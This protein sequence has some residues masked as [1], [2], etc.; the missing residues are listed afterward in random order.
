MGSPQRQASPKT[1]RV[2][3]HRNRSLSPAERSQRGTSG[4]EGDDIDGERLTV[5]VDQT[6]DGRLGFSVRGGA[7][8]G[9]H[10]FISKVEPHSA[11]AQAGLCVGDK[12]LEVNG[13]SLENISMSSAVK[14]LTGHRR[15]RLVLQRVG[16]VPGV[17]Y[18]NEKTTWVD[19]IHRRMVVD[20][21]GAALSDSRSDAALCRTV[22]LQTSLSQPFLGLNIRGGTEYGLGIYVSKLDPGGLA[23]Q[24]GIKMG[25]QILS[26]NG[27][28]FEDVTHSRAVEVLK[29]RSHV[30]LIIKEAGRYPAY[31]EM[32]AE[33]TWMDKR[34]SKMYHSSSQGSDSHSSASSMSSGTPLSSVAGLSQATLPLCLPFGSQMV[35][36][37]SFSEDQFSSDHADDAFHTEQMETSLRRGPTELLQ[38]SAIR[39]AG[40]EDRKG[41]EENKEGRKTSLLMA[42]SRPSPPIRRTQSHM[43]VSEDEQR[44]Q[45][46]KQRESRENGQSPPQ[47]SRTL[48]GLRW[49]R[50]SSKSPSRSEPGHGTKNDGLSDLDMLTQVEEMAAKLLEEE[51]AAVVMEICRRYTEKQMDY[52]LDLYTYRVSYTYTREQELKTLVLPLLAILDRPEKLLLLRE[53]RMLVVKDDLQ[54]FNG[55]VAPLE[56]EAYDILKR[57]SRRSSPLRSPQAGHA[58]KRH[59]ITP[60][61]DQQGGFEL[62][63]AEDV[64][65]RNRLLEELKRIQVTQQQGEMSEASRAF[66]PLLDIP[67][68]SYSH[69]DSPKP[70]ETSLVFPNWLLT[71]NTSPAPDIGLVNSSEDQSHLENSRSKRWRLPFRNGHAETKANRQDNE[72]QDVFFTV[73]DTPHPRR[74]LLSQVFGPLKRSQSSTVPSA[75]SSGQK[76]K[77]KRGLARSGSEGSHHDD[78]IDQ[79]YELKTVSISKTKQSLGISISGGVESRVQPMVR[80]EKIFPGGAAS[81]N[82]ILKVGSGGCYRVSV[83]MG[84]PWR[85]C[86]WVGGLSSREVSNGVMLDCHGVAQNGSGSS[87]VTSPA[88][89]LVETPNESVCGGTVVST[90]MDGLVVTRQTSRRP[91]VAPPPP[92]PHHLQELCEDVQAA[93]DGLSQDSIRNLYSSIPRRL[94]CWAGFE[95]VSVD[96]VSLQGITHEDAVEIIRQA[97]SNKHVDPMELVVKVPKHSLLG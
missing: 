57:R 30:T 73:V 31:Q 77:S 88:L 80:I 14:V 28:S 94:A 72:E 43:T 97:F 48:F 59:L 84:G 51:D 52:S 76:Q 50:N 36:M 18:K 78:R 15:L 34:N 12:L 5:T 45:K 96:G 92:L 63:D 3:H 66:S 38:D 49:K 46:K 79:E 40:G 62:Q 26:A 39:N 27:V 8:H 70:S 68:D 9:L 32:V 55:M 71:E 11:A 6:Q 1:P 64:D 86:L 41:G 22:H 25:D 7:E 17:R 69:S 35:D 54:Q 33:Y 87:S 81:S 60:V 24:G 65:R 95:L 53:I 16:W 20:E 42:L 23:E 61:P 93:W 83:S 13:I 19:L 74:P 37:S 44:K 10:I 4:I 82:D 47:R 85:T 67:V 2:G 89:V 91:G 58:P 56:E 21:G 75:G 29:S 90:E